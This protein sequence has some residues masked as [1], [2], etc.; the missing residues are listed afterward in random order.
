MIPFSPW[1]P[2]LKRRAVYLFHLSSWPRRVPRLAPYH[3]QKVRPCHCEPLED[4]AVVRRTAATRYWLARLVW[5]YLRMRYAHRV[6]VSR[7]ENTPHIHT[8]LH[9][10]SN[11]R[12][13]DGGARFHW[14][15]PGV[16]VRCCH[17]CY[18]SIHSRMTGFLTTLRI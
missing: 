1:P 10:D 18:S 4:A 2:C 8:L 16:E 15:C 12:C 3:N 17:L 5:R 14:A 6:G 13:R 11:G 7:L 9:P